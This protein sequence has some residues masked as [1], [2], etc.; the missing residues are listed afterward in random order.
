MLIT[1][2]PITL[3]LN[4]FWEA[5]GKPRMFEKPVLLPAPAG[6]CG[7]CG[8]SCIRKGRLFPC[9]TSPG[10]ANAQSREQRSMPLYQAESQGFPV[11]LWMGHLWPCTC[12]QHRRVCW[13]RLL[14]PTHVCIWR[15]HCSGGNSHTHFM[16]PNQGRTWRSSEKHD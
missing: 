14:G 11:H 4:I 13:A 3:R 10:L 9:G 12:G 5:D 15:Y 7:P 8:L 1:F 2:V 6:T 16:R